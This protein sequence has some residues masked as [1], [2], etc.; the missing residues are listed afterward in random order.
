MPSLVGSEMWIR[1]R[2]IILPTNISELTE[3]DYLYNLSSHVDVADDYSLIALCHKEK[4]SNFVIAGRGSKKEMATSVVPIFVKSGKSTNIFINSI[5]KGSKVIISGS[6]LSLGHHVAVTNNDLNMSKFASII[7]GDSNAMR[8][9]LALNTN[10]YFVE[11]KLIPNNEIIG[12]YNPID[13]KFINPF[14]ISLSQ[15]ADH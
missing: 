2:C 4:L 11:F 6:A 14:C 12:I 7:D 15:V 5:K 8:N 9:A 3:H 13:D 1:A 10:V